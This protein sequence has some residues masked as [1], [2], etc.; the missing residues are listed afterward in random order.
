M[1]SSF[2]AF[3]KSCHSSSSLSM[4]FTSRTWQVQK[5]RV[6]N[7]MFGD[8]PGF[9]A[10]LLT[11]ASTF[12]SSKNPSGSLSAIDF[13]CSSSIGSSS[14]A[15]SLSSWF[16]FPLLPLGSPFTLESKKSGQT[17]KTKRLKSE[18]RFTVLYSILCNLEMVAHLPEVSRKSCLRSNLLR[19]TMHMTREV[20]TK[21]GD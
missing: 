11:F 6:Q 9:E 12:G 1:F 19:Q 13:S 2:I 4:N 3:W 21:R 17:K 8:F 18:V 16:E 14:S 7:E 5:E 10:C 15:A 20:S